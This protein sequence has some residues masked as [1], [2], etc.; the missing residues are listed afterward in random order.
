MSKER[1]VY[2]SPTCEVFECRL[3]G[4]IAASTALTIYALFGDTGVTDGDTFGG[5]DNQIQ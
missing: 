1:N 3:E 4:V 5:W 2:D